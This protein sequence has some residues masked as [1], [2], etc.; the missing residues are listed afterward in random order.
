MNNLHLIECSTLLS[1]R[2]TYQIKGVLY[3]FASKDGSIQ[4]PQ[5]IFRP[6][7]G[8]KKKADLRLNHQKLLTQCYVVP[9]MSAKAEL[10]ST[11]VVQMTLF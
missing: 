7:A 2:Q 10:T 1:Y 3:R 9:G 11:K 8:Q 5:Y 4:H 6:L